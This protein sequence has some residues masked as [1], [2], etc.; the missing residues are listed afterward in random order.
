MKTKPKQSTNHALTLKGFYKTVKP[1]APKRI[2][3]MPQVIS[4]P[5]QLNAHEL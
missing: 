5:N 2:F 4:K 1:T 3:F